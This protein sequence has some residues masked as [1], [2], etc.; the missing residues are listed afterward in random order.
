[1]SRKLKLSVKNLSSH[2][3]R[4]FS[5]CHTWDGHGTVCQGT[6]LAND[7]ESPSVEMTSGSIKYD[8][9]TVQLDIDGLGVRQTDFYCNS[10]A[11]DV[12]CMVA[13]HETYVNLIYTSKDGNTDG[14]NDKRYSSMYQDE[15]NKVDS[16]KQQLE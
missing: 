5:V 16:V 14:C 2:T 15:Q 4:S 6:M 8:W 12:K 7:Q 1:M 10:S 9:F 3:V 13:V 11:N